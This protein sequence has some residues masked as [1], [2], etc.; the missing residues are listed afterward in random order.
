MYQKYSTRQR[1]NVTDNEYK[2]DYK[3]ILLSWCVHEYWSE[4]HFIQNDDHKQ[5]FL[6]RSDHTFAQ[7]TNEYVWGKPN[8]N[9][10]DWHFNILAD[11]WF[12]CKSFR[13][14]CHL[15][16]LN[17]WKLLHNEVIQEGETPKRSHFVSFHRFP[18]HLP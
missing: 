7:Y 14:A 5:H 11:L 12:V 16:D 3:S 1:K 10:D 18:T 15:H 6:L 13:W 8:E 17:S 9:T 4:L 2:K